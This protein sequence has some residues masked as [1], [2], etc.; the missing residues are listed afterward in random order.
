M[1][2]D[3]LRINFFLSLMLTFIIAG[4]SLQKPQIEAAKG[5]HGTM[6]SQTI[7]AYKKQLDATIPKIEPAMFRVHSGEDWM[8]VLSVEKL[9]L[10]LNDTFPLPKKE[11][12]S[13]KIEVRNKERSKVASIDYNRGRVRYINKE[14][15]FRWTEKPKHSIQMETARTIAANGLKSIG[16]PASEMG[17]LRVDTIMGQHFNVADPTK[18]S[19]PFERDRLVTVERRGY[20]YPVFE[21]Y[22]RLAISNKGEIARLFIIWPKFQLKPNLM[23]VQREPVIDEV[24]DYLFKTR[25]G[26]QLELDAELA[27]VSAGSFYI[28]AVVLTVIDDL[29]LEDIVVP[30][31][32]VPKDRDFDGITDRAD[33]CPDKLNPDQGDQDQD[34]V[35]D[36]CD[37]CPGIADPK[38]PDSNADGIGDQCDP[39][40]SHGK[41]EQQ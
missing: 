23:P 31:A 7:R 35:G 32:I 38:Q 18:Q 30:L 5:K 3:N 1:Q 25:R 28:P 39:Q 4:C 11:K 37:V 20:G 2:R 15:T 10:S 36:R 21:E 9:A 33:N 40:R 12:K 16:V 29:I 6:P 41:V 27:Y 24:A 8:T 17:R 19:Q 26:R 22:A 13:N 14:R 34:G